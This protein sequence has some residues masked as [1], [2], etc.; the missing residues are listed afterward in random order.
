MTVAREIIDSVWEHHT[1]TTASPGEVRAVLASIWVQSCEC[2]D[3]ERDHVAALNQL[4]TVAVPAPR[5]AAIWE[6]LKALCHRH[7]N[8][9]GGF[10]RSILYAE[11]REED[12]DI[13]GSVADHRADRGRLISESKAFV[14][15]YRERTY[16]TIA[17]EPLRLRPS[18]QT[19][20]N[21]EAERGSLLIIGQPGV[22]KT[23]S[24]VTL[25]A[26][27]Q[28]AHY[29]AAFVPVDRLRT[30]GGS[31]EKLFGLRKPIREV[32]ADWGGAQP[33]FFIID[34][35][36]AARGADELNNTLE[37]LFQMASSASPRWRFVVSM[38]SYDALRARRQNTELPVIFRVS[39]DA[40]KIS[41]RPEL[42]GIRCFEVPELTNEDLA[43]ARL[44]LRAL[45]VALENGDVLKLA[46]V[47]FNL[48]LLIGLI[49][50]GLVGSELQSITTQIHLLNTYWERRVE[51]GDDTIDRERLLTRACWLMIQ[52]RTLTCDR[53]QLLETGQDERIAND[54][55]SVG[56][57]DSLPVSRAFTAAQYRFSHNTL[58]DFAVAKR[59]LSQRGELDRLLADNPGALTLI[60]PSLRMFFQELWDE[61]AGTE[62]RGRFWTTLLD[63]AGN[64]SLPAVASVIAVA[65]ASREAETAAEISKLVDGLGNPRTR[66]AALRII[67]WI[68]GSL[69][70]DGLDPFRN[71]GEPWD[72]LARAL[73]NDPGDGADWSSFRLQSMLLE[74]SDYLG[75]IAFEN[76]S[77]AARLLLSHLLA[78]AVR[79]DRFISVAIANVVKSARSDVDSAVRALRPLLVS[80]YR[81]ANA[82]SDMP[83]LA[84]EL[85]RLY[86]LAPDF[87]AEVYDG[88]FHTEERSEEKVSMSQSRIFGLVSNKRQD[89]EHAKWQLG[90]DYPSFF[91][92]SPAAATRAV[93]AAVDAYARTE[94]VV[95]IGDG[96]RIQLGSISLHV[97]PDMSSSWLGSVLT[98]HQ[99]A[100]GM[101]DAWCKGM[102]DLYRRDVDLFETCLR[103]YVAASWSAVYWR[104]LLLAAAQYPETVGRAAFDL[105]T[106]DAVLTGHD[107][108][109]A[110]ADAVTALYPLLSNEE[111]AAIEH[112]ILAL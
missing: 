102:D 63:I 91:N 56:V 96:C 10:D 107:T 52:G 6:R 19:S 65:V 8:I 28:E 44:R 101:L 7:S 14:D 57:L 17:G 80:N 77:S 34:G 90:R 20:L 41:M 22:G 71:A 99:P 67:E 92:V 111:R 72:Y 11:V 112:A 48:G 37:T 47:P 87:V 100:F 79:N 68:H 24:V 5:A 38:R 25:Y 103:E 73:M 94:R 55:C 3:N 54:L 75:N 98:Q 76:V 64:E 70:I 53:S 45:D 1:G 78:D 31:I 36:D 109:D 81:A 61:G 26:A 39:A 85:S 18:T 42:E 43:P 104:K 66:R 33:A 83:A 95:A 69:G 21:S 49:E 4:R 35:L 60:V 9:G 12:A 27:C 40:P 46:R 15:R 88:C 58:F 106:Q 108:I 84:R 62:G 82:W 2:D 89:L 30:G 93:V 29:E 59:I 86:V 16:I 105:L 32:M 51:H 97:T 110:A 50:Q 74:Q 13:L 23:G